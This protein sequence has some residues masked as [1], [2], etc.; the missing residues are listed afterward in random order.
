MFS[1]EQQLGAIRR[2]SLKVQA[3]TEQLAQKETTSRLLANVVNEC[4]VNSMI[5]KA[6]TAE[7]GSLWMCITAR[8]RPSES[9]AQRGLEN[10]SKIWIS[11]SSVDIELA[12]GVDV[13]ISHGIIDPEDFLFPVIIESE[14]GFKTENS[15]GAV[16][17]IMYPWFG[18]DHSSSIRSE[19]IREL[20]DS[21]ANQARWLELAAKT[22]LP[23]LSSPSIAWEKSMIRG[24]P[25]H[26]M[27]KTCL[28]QSPLQDLQPSDFPRIINPGISFVSIPISDVRLA[29]NFQ[30]TIAPLLSACGVAAAEEG[31]V[32]APCLSMQLP[33]IAQRFPSAKVVDSNQI[34]AE[35][36]ASLRTV[37]LPSELNFPYHLKFPLACKVTSAVRTIT[38]WTT[39]VGPELSVLLESV[40]DKDFWPLK[41]VASLAG[42]QENFSDARHLSCLVREDLEIRARAQGEA[43]IVASG[44]AER[45]AENKVTNV[46]RVLGLDTVEKK[47]DWLRGYA[48]KLFEVTIPLLSRYG[49]C[50]ESHGQNILVRLG[51][52]DGAL[53]GFAVRDLGGIRMHLP[54]LRKCGFELKTALPGSSIITEDIHEVWSKAYHT[55][56]QN[57][58]NQFIHGLSIQGEGGWRVVKEELKGVLAMEQGETARELE[59]FFFAERVPFKCFMRMQMASVYRNYIY[60]EVPNMLLR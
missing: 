39:C 20:E 32:I 41:E 26:P 37:S 58:L 31:R 50:L 59:R 6:S 5:L 29:G 54:T 12:E 38:P 42:A 35:A 18:D 46:E 4:L 3:T 51:L 33:S 16:F 60:E 13:V 55:L 53:K 28:A 47:L 19:T 8:P 14:A 52:S 25:T 44:L 17:D 43:L 24:H 22:P 11:L 45:D 36:Q 21:A 10:N 2:A 34:T 56:I 40:M 49:I 15:P 23:E 9:L 7:E 1:T 27:H 48:R 30:D 57:H